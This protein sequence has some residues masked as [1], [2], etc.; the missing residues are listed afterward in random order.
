MVFLPQSWKYGA[1]D[2]PRLAL[3]CVPHV[4][5]SRRSAMEAVA[6][7][8]TIPS[9]I[10]A[11]GNASRQRGGVAQ[12]KGFEKADASK[13]FSCNVCEYVLLTSNDGP[14]NMQHW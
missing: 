8:R 14:T 5:G 12:V 4:V 11:E 2:H 7:S 3:S 6:P 1:Q 9:G 10:P 13:R